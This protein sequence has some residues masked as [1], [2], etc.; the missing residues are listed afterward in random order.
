MTRKRNA[1]WT[2]C[3]SLLPGAAEMYMG[4]LKMGVSLMLG[5]F[6]ICFLA[7]V[8]NFGPLMF[9][10]IVAW[11]YGFFHAH[12]LAGLSDQEFY[13][14]ED[15]YLFDAKKIF[16]EEKKMDKTVHAVLAAVLIL[17]GIALVW[18][19][20]AGVLSIFVPYVFMDIIE[21]TMEKAVQLIVGG[22][23]IYLGVMMIRG[24]KKNLETQEA[25]ETQSQPQS[26]PQNQSV[27]ELPDNNAG[28][29]D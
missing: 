5:F 28:K 2:F 15:T 23:I 9:V 11:F 29:E 26:Q 6:G 25:A 19:G 12:T 4:F 1:F 16:P 21:E 14:V 8:L 27:I 13:Q 3:F 22:G 7:T 17:I 10:A 24:K 20:V 18:R